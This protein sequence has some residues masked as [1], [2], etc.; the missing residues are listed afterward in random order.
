MA[1]NWI[2]EGLDHAKIGL[3]HDNGFNVFES[4]ELNETSTVVFDFA[5]CL[6][7]FSLVDCQGKTWLNFII[8]TSVCGRFRISN[9]IVFRK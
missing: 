5:Q 1:C 6:L 8:H 7:I 9:K 4:R 3:K 2:V